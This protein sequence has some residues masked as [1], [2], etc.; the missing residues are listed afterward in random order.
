MIKKDESASCARPT[1]GAVLAVALPAMSNG[2]EAYASVAFAAQPKREM[3]EV[4]VKAARVSLN[5]RGAA[6]ADVL[7]AIGREAGVKVVL[8]DALT[9]LVTATLVNVPL[10]DAFRR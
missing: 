8:R 5:A 6:L 2:E 10:E 1:T 3:L 9:T 7:A 4:T